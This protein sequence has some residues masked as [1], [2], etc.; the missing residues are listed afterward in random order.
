M[1]GMVMGTIGG[2]NELTIIHTGRRQ[3]QTRTPFLTIIITKKSTPFLFI[4]NNIVLS[5]TAKAGTTS[6][7][8]FVLCMPPSLVSSIPF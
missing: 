5:L 1:R 8:I 2:L 4:E 6:Q 7:T 3:Q